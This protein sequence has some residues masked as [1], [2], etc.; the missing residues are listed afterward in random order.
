MPVDRNTS[1]KSQLV[2]SPF[3]KICL[4]R[5][6]N[7]TRQTDASLNNQYIYIYIYYIRKSSQTKQY[8]VNPAP[9]CAICICSVH[10][11][12]PQVDLMRYPP[13]M[14]CYHRTDRIGLQDSIASLQILQ[15][16]CNLHWFGA[17]PIDQFHNSNCFTDQSILYIQ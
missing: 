4:T 13:A 3:S 12:C 16:L 17:I 8:R 11:R 14:A 7:K 15:Y 10:G 1:L 9:I 6:Q 5:E 2:G